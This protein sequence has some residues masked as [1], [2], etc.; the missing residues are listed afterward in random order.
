[1][2]KLLTI[3]AIALLTVSCNKEVVKTYSATISQSG[4]NA[5][6]AEEFINEL[7]TI[8]WEY[9]S[10]GVYKGTRSGGFPLDNT[11]TLCNN[12]VDG[13]ISGDLVHYDS[14]FIILRTFAGTNVNTGVPEPSNGCAGLQIQIQIREKKKP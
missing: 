9:V 6:A 5:P 7:G 11:F 12:G 8:S 4:T 1:M 3:L 14:E 13:Y 10:V 2:K